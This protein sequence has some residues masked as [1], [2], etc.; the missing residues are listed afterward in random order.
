MRT[1]TNG[2]L[3]VVRDNN[4]DVVLATSYDTCL[5][6]SKDGVVVFNATKYSSTTSRHQGK[7]RA[8]CDN[9]VIVRDCDQ[10]IDAQQL[11][12]CAGL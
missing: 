7:V 2:A 9:V 3:T 10:G 11:L 4:G 8:M 5:L 1:E 12:Q 6:A